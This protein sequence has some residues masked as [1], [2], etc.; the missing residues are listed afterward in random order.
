M[1]NPSALVVTDPEAFATFVREAAEYDRKTAALRAYKRKLIRE[2]SQPQ[3]QK[4]L[5]TGLD[6]L[7]GQSD[8]FDT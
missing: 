7:E 1:T 2:T 4:V 8:L 3:K 6:C 5:L